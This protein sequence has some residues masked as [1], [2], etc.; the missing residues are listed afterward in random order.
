MGGKRIRVLKARV[1]YECCISTD[2]PNLSS[3]GIPPG[4]V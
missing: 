3:G 1:G 2:G 4:A